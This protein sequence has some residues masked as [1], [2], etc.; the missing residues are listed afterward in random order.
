MKRRDSIT[1]SA[2]TFKQLCLLLTHPMEVSPR[3]GF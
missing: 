2:V 3:M 1:Q